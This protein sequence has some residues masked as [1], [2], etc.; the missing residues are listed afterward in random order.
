VH[1]RSKSGIVKPN[2]KYHAN[3]STRYPIPHAFSALVNTN[4]E[5]TCY[6]QAM[7]DEYHALLQQ[8]AWSLVPSSPSL[9]MVGCKW[10]FRIKRRSDGTIERYKARLVAKGFHQ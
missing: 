9:N 5:P 6:T 10:V 2:P 3:I 8:G 1:T 4:I 7:L